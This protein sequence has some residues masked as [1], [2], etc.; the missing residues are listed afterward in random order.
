[1]K[2]RLD[3]TTGFKGEEHKAKNLDLDLVGPIDKFDAM[4]K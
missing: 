4:N 2:R 3:A 1:V